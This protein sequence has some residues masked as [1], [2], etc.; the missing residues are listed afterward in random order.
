MAMM[1][2][3]EILKSGRCKFL[4]QRKGVASGYPFS[5]IGEHFSQVLLRDMKASIIFAENPPS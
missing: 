4:K 1:F 3:T 2:G 5:F